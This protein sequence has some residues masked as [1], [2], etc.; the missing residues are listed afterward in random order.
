M[1]G[2]FASRGVENRVGIAAPTFTQQM[3]H[4]FMAPAKKEFSAKAFFTDLAIVRARRRFNPF[5]CAV[6]RRRRTRVR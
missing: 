5:H 4:Q 6:L 1:A 3:T 2:S